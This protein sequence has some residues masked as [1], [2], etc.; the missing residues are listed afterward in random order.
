MCIRD[1]RYNGLCIFVV[2][3][4]I[5][6]TNKIMIKIIRIKALIIFVI[7][8]PIRNSLFAAKYFERK[9]PEIETKVII[10]HNNVNLA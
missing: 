1:S 8:K 2:Q 3:F 10:N 7:L 5:Y 6:D 4:Y 9:Y